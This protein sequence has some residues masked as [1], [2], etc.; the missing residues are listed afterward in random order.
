MLF[1]SLLTALPCA[2]AVL[3]EPLQPRA[4]TDFM[5]YAYGPSAIGGFPIFAENNL[6]FVTSRTPSAF[7]SSMHNVTF[8]SLTTHG[9]FTATQ[10]DNGESL[11]YIPT[12]SGQV[13]FTNS[14]NSSVITTGFGFYGH[15]IYVDIDDTLETQWFAQSTS[16]DDIW[17]LFWGNTTADAIP[18]SLR[19]VAPS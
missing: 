4:M 16:E 9:N 12:T 1:R 15:T 14:T 2:A 7:N 18:V 8:D 17:A 6:A 19:T 10:F 5:I 11:F 13:G 3:S